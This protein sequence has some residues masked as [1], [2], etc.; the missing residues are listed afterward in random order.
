MDKA[1][2]AEANSGS[3][4]FQPTQPSGASLL[5]SSHINVCVGGWDV[6]YSE[7]LPDSILSIHG[8]PRVRYM[9]STW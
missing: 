4:D 2:D 5:T 7:R 1:G 6:L 9:V 8:L 3:S